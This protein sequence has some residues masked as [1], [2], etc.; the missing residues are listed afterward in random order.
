L[1]LP[2]NQLSSKI[3]LF[4]DGNLQPKKI[5]ASRQLFFGVLR[6]GARIEPKSPDVAAISEPV[7]LCNAGIFWGDQPGNYKLLPAALVKVT[8]ILP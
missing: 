7:D 5:I 1:V 2:K 4:E 6:R 8:I 3:W